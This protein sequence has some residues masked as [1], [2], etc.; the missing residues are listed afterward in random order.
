MSNERTLT[1]TSAQLADIRDGRS[2]TATESLTRP[3]VTL[4]GPGFTGH[5]TEPSV[6]LGTF[7]LDTFAAGPD[8]RVI[9]ST[10]DRRDAWTLT[11][12]S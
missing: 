9:V 3:T 1:I 5:V 8:E 6:R 10:D 7:E 2:V 4:Y 11:V 12:T